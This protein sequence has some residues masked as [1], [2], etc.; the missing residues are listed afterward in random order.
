MSMDQKPGKVKSVSF[1]PGFYDRHLPVSGFFII[2]YLLFFMHTLMYGE[3]IN[4]DFDLSV[5]L[6]AGEPVVSIT[7]A[8]K[9]DRQIK[10]MSEEKPFIILSGKGVA[11]EHEGKRVQT[12]YIRDSKPEVLE[13]PFTVDEPSGEI[14]ELSLRL[15]MTYVPCIIS[16]GVCKFPVTMER[17]Y[18]L[19]A[20]GPGISPAF[21]NTG[22][23]IAL[24]VLAVAGLVVYIRMKKDI[25][26]TVFLVFVFSGILTYTFVQADS[27]NITQADL[28]R[29]IAGTL[30]LSCIGLEQ[31]RQ[32]VP[33]NREKTGILSHLEEQ[34]LITVFSAPWCGSCPAAKAYV[35][36]LCSLYP[37]TLSWEEV[38]ISSPEGKDKFA[39]YRMLYTFHDP[40][41][42][43]AIIVSVNTA[44]VFY[45]TQNIEEN[46]LQLITKG[47]DSGEDGK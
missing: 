38:D 19:K 23:L 11:F 35:K 2:V 1:F 5:K 8:P 37:D 39:H 4:D 7:I 25:L 46:I 41:P 31:A 14:N 34:V 27:N 10:G 6:I 36:E 26:F 13:F 42:L 40:I 15:E 24:F 22:I 17:E 29:D 20:S 12:E 28:A 43:P 18:E 30:C 32:S 3:N 45:G 47:M 44:D 21:I 9:R 16:S 33:V